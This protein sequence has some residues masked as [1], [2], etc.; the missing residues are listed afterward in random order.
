MMNSRGHFTYPSKICKENGVVP[1][2]KG[3]IDLVVLHTP[4]YCRRQSVSLNTT[5]DEYIT[6]EKKESKFSSK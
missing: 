6:V 5:K 1:K 4:T 2:G 3:M